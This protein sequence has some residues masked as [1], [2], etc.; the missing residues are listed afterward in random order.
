MD[1]FDDNPFDENLCDEPSTDVGGVKP[2]SLSHLI[3]QRT[4]IEQVKTAIDAAQMDGLRM[5][6]AL[7]VGPPGVGKSALASVIAQEMA[8]EF[9]EVLGQSIKNPS[10]LNA[11]L[12]SAKDRDIVH[13]DEAHELDRRFQTALYLACDQHKLI[14]N[15]GKKPQTLPIADFTLLLSTTDEYH[16][17]PPLRDRMKL[18]LRFDFYSHEDLRTLVEQR[19]KALRWDVDDCTI[20]SIANRAR[21]TPRIALRLLQAC[22]RVC[23]AEGETAITAK[24]LYRA[25]ELE[26]MD[27]LGL[28]PCEKRYLLILADGGSRL[29]VIA[30]TLGLPTRTVSQ[31]VEPFLIRL[32]LILKDDQGRR[33]L[34][35]KGREHLCNPFRSEDR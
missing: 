8:S 15:G 26:Q 33:E 32:G 27:D 18:V 28:G 12:L 22:R 29:N 9:H 24:H 14:V 20:L 30:S 11:L 31:V 7:L 10:D 13:I 34:S 16:L 25:C 35:A 5:D 3:G 6:S 23:R 17:L 1:E 4:V 2:T 19:A 21:G